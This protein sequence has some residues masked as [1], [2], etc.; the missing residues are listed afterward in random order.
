MG[1]H[2]ELDDQPF[3][4]LSGGILGFVQPVRGNADDIKGLDLIGNAL[5]KM[6]GVGTKQNA[7]LVKGMEMLEGHVDVRASHVVVKKIEDGIVFL[8]DMDVILILI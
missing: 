3:A 2:V 1:G 6:D 8:I 4:G 5:D 7:K